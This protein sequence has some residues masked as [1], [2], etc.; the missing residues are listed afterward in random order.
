MTVDLRRWKWGRAALGGALLALAAPPFPPALIALAMLGAILLATTLDDET[1]LGRALLYG[2]TFGL[3]TNLV[4]MSFVPQT[5]TRFT[6]L[7]SVVAVT[8]WVLLSAAQG[9]VWAIAAVVAWG[10]GRLG[11]PRALAFAAGVGAS[12]FVP[13][14]VPWTLGG[15][16]ARAPLF[17]QPAELIRERGMA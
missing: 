7:P 17:L 3:A 5:I 6:D 9:L 12:V 8:G 1:T 11:V 15:P 16:F 2:F 13:A 14:L 4:A 10:L